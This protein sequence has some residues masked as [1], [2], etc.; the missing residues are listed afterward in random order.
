V[1]TREWKI[2]NV[3]W[4]RCLQWSA[5][6]AMLVSGSFLATKTA[7]LVGQIVQAIV[8]HP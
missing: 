6:V 1:L 5:L 3:N 7:A 8:A 2:P 4:K